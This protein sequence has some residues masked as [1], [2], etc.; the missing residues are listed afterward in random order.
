MT[1]AAFS[2]VADS[3][4]RSVVGRPFVYRRRPRAALR[5]AVRRRS[6]STRWVRGRRSRRRPRSQR[7]Q[8]STRRVPAAP[9]RA[10]SL[11]SK[12]CWPP[13]SQANVRPRLGEPYGRFSTVRV[14]SSLLILVPDHASARVSVKD[15]L[16]R[17]VVECRLRVSRPGYSLERR[18]FFPVIA[19]SNGDLY[20]RSV[21]VTLSCL[22]ESGA[23]AVSDVRRDA[24]ECN[25]IAGRVFL[26]VWSREPRRC[27]RTS[28][29]CSG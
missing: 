25:K 24:A 23:R 16:S 13:V 9:S 29:R 8:R 19:K 6:L 15:P 22:V 20:Q 11:G 21:A 18:L 27:R 1:R 3:N 17:M 10:A 2:L 5:S 7:T 26:L 4:A 12:F 28:L 14:R